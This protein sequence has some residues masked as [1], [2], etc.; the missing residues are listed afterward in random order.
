MPNLEGTEDLQELRELMDE[1]NEINQ[2]V[3]L[4]RECCEC[5]I[6]SIQTRKRGNIMAAECYEKVMQDHYNNL[7]KWAKW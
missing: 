3:H 5:R 4:L 7:P 1:L 6:K 2:A